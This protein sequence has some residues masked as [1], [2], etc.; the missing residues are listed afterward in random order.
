MAYIVN[1][2]VKHL[3]TS[4][5]GQIPNPNQ[6]RTGYSCYEASGS[7]DMMNPLN[8][9]LT[10][11]MIAT[12]VDLCATCE[13]TPQCAAWYLSALSCLFPGLLDVS[14]RAFKESGYNV[15]VRNEAT[16]GPLLI[17]LK[18]CVD[19]RVC[20]AMIG[21]IILIMYKNID[22]RSYR[23]YFR[24]RANAIN[25][26]AGLDTSLLADGS[27]VLFDIEIAR[28]IKK[29]AGSHPELRSAVLVLILNNRHGMTRVAKVCAYLAEIIGWTEMSAFMF[30]FDTLC[31][32]KS[33]V[34]RDHRVKNEVQ[35][36]MDAYQK[37][38]STDQPQYYTI[39]YPIEAAHSLNRSRFETLMEVSRQIRS[40]QKR[41]VAQFAA[42]SNVRADP[43]IAALVKMHDA[44]ML[45]VKP[46][47]FHYLADF[48]IDQ[49]ERE[50]EQAERNAAAQGGGGGGDA[51][52]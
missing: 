22:D 41:N 14:K 30:V 44:H 23:E 32:T 2:G 46:G 38:T 48:D 11:N 12:C 47:A 20:L 29:F 52:V 18:P 50:M 34:L 43:L 16:I 36:L 15:T 10:P 1:R 40:G 8:T 26:E 9:R 45:K 3:H 31:L 27:D 19:N 4:Y 28:K 49:M 51:V 24:K 25:K 37:I 21:Q 13:D 33:P 42:G 7:V 5:G 17:E 35:Y 39:F 6:L